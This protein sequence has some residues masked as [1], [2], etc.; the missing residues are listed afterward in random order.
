MIEP[1][2]RT[3]TLIPES[4]TFGSTPLALFTCCPSYPVS[5]PER[6]EATGTSHSFRVFITERSLRAYFSNP[7]FLLRLKGERS[8]GHQGNQSM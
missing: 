8:K 6:E 7:L 5:L 4:L 3:R 2:F 1:L